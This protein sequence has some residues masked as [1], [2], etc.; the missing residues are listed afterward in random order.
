MTPRKGQKYD[1]T[2]NQLASFKSLL[3]GVILFYD[4]GGVSGDACDGENI[5]TH[6]TDV[7]RQSEHIKHD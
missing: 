2:D 6:G 4:N 3:F 7:G 1:Y 5:D